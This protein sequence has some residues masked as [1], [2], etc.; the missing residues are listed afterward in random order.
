[1]VNRVGEEAVSE[2]SE[3]ATWTWLAVA[4]SPWLVTVAEV[5]WLA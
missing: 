4:V 3:R 5:L 2:M 1:M